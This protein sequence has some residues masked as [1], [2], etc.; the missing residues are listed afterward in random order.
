MQSTSLTGGY[1]IVQ[2]PLGWT[3]GFLG[4]CP[5]QLKFWL[6]M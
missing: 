6:T 1:S 3:D 5:A 4:R 2:M